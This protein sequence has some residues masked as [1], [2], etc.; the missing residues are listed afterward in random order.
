MNFGDKIYSVGKANYEYM[1]DIDPEKE[2]CQITFIG[3][4][5]R[6]ETDYRKTVENIKLKKSYLIS[7]YSRTGNIPSAISLLTNALN[8]GARDNYVI[9]Q[10]LR[11]LLKNNPNLLQDIEDGLENLDNYDK[12][13]PLNKEEN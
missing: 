13:G 7:N 6:N 8:E 5:F 9:A 1:L 3:R 4:N 2:M 11:L 12:E 10:S